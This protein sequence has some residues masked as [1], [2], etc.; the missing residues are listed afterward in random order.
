[1]GNTN[2]SELSP[3][4]RFHL[5]EQKRSLLINGFCRS[6]LAEIYNHNQ[7][8]LNVITH[9]VMTYY[10]YIINALIHKLGQL[11]NCNKNNSNHY[12]IIAFEISKML[13][14][15]HNLIRKQFRAATKKHG[16]KTE[17]C[18]KYYDK[19]LN[20]Y[21]YIDKKLNYDK[22]SINLMDFVCK[23]RKNG[24]GK[25][26]PLCPAKTIDNYSF[27]MSSDPSGIYNGIYY[28]CLSLTD[29]SINDKGEVPYLKCTDKKYNKLEFDKK[30][31]NIWLHNKDM[32][33]NNNK[34]LWIPNTKLKYIRCLT[35]NQ[36][37]NAH[38]YWRLHCV[39]LNNN[40]KLKHLKW[41]REHKL[42]E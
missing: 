1:M 33:Y 15:S 8:D 37:N 14:E 2:V 36:Y 31:L 11:T 13:I 29:L 4:Q 42:N 21:L 38:C 19:K 23:S 27:L 17:H 7:F 34:N 18:D 35:R 39:K 25:S 32:I 6:I 9:I 30:R 26:L 12:L 28:R 41:I 20:K 16:L 3:L 22:M 40:G 24:I 10:D 5:Q